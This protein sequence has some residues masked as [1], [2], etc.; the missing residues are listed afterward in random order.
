MIPDSEG[1]VVGFEGTNVTISF[2]SDV[3]S[4]LK[5]KEL[6]IIIIEILFQQT[7][8]IIHSLNKKEA[9]LYNVC[10]VVLNRIY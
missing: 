10:V 1:I 7:E 3:I 5:Q 4:N 9:S 2:E 6:S 8:P